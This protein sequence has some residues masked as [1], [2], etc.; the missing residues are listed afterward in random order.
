VVAVVVEGIGNS[1]N[2][3]CVRQKKA[4]HYVRLIQGGGGNEGSIFSHRFQ[5]PEHGP[6]AAR[7]TRVCTELNS[8]AWPSC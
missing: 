6:N 5:W 4:L 7:Y 8:I 3:M 1:F 2:Y